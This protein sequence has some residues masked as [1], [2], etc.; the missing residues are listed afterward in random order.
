MIDLDREKGG[1]V[2][3]LHVACMRRLCGW[4]LGKK[5]QKSGCKTLAAEQLPFPL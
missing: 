5:V 3:W 2:R 4:W 1:R